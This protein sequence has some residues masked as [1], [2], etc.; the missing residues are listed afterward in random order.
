MILIGK[1]KRLMVY[2]SYEESLAR[3]VR[4]YNEWKE[5]GDYTIKLDIKNV[6]LE[7]ELQ[8][9]AFANPVKI[10]D[11]MEELGLS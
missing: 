3:A 6:Q 1:L 10:E 11:L 7:E 5:R 8:I 9:I 4:E 2:I